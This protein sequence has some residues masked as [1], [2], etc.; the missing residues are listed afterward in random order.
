M[1]LAGQCGAG[2][3]ITGFATPRHRPVRGSKLASRNTIL[4]D[5]VCGIAVAASLPVICA[6]AAQDFSALPIALASNRAQTDIASSHFGGASANDRAAYMGLGRDAVRPGN[7]PRGNPLWAISLESL[8][9]TRE[10]PLLLPGRRRP[11]PPPVSVA[12]P[13]ASP[14]PPSAPPERVRLA[15][16]GAVAAASEGIAVFFDEATKHVIRLRTGESHAGWIL[17]SVQGREVTIEKGRERMQLALPATTDQG[18]IAQARAA[19]TVAEAAGNSASP[20]LPPFVERAPPAVTVPGSTVPRADG[21]SSPPLPPF[22]ERAPPA[23][24]VPGSAVPSSD[25]STAPVLPPF[26]ERAPPAVAVPSSTVPSSDGSTA[27]VLPPF[28]DRAPPAVTNPGATASPSGGSISPVLPP[29]INPTVPATDAA[30]PT[31]GGSSPAT[32]RP[33]LG[34][35]L[36][37]PDNAPLR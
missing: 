3:N 31:G 14:P 25:G 22:V 19:I 17:R 24:A 21:S 33:R 35:D 26:V 4:L 18:G 32:P 20:P 23:V 37:R 30:A 10:R 1:S 29:S 6:R 28:V 5:V 34:I 7:E 11:A 36:V 2:G 15:L 16:I 8:T 9:A 13:P 12:A 27:P